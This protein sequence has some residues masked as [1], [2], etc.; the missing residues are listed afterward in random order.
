MI[1]RESAALVP[2]IA[3]AEIRASWAAAR[4]LIGEVGGGKKGRAKRRSTTAGTGEPG[5]TGAGRALA[6]EMR[7]FDHAKDTEPTEGFVTIAGGKA[8]TLRAM[9]EAAADVVCTKL[10]LVSPCQTVDYILLPHAAWYSA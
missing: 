1:I 9:A 10:G 6:R 7:C 2:A 3:R 8:T 4:P 5:G